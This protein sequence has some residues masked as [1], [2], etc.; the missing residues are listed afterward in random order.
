MLGNCLSSLHLCLWIAA[1]CLDV[2]FGMGGCLVVVVLVV[3]T[4][5]LPLLG[6]QLLVR[7]SSV[8]V[9]IRLI[10]LVLGL[11]LSIGMQ[12]I[13]PW[14]CLIILIFGLMVAGRISFLSVGLK[15]QALVF[16]CLLLKL[17]LIARCVGTAEEYGD[18]RLERCRAFLP[19]LGVMRTV[20]RAEFCGAILALQA[21]WPCHL[22]TDHLHV[23]RTIGR[24]LDKDCLVKPLPLI[25][26][27][28][29][30]ALVQYMIRTRGRG[31]VR[32]TKV[33]GHAEDLDV[34]QGRVRLKD[35]LV[36][37]EADTAADLGRRHQS[38]VLV[39]ARRRLLK[40]RSHW[41]PVMLHLHRFMIAVARVTVNHDGRGR[42]APD[43]TGIRV[44]QKKKA[45]RLDIFV[46]MLNLPLFLA[47]LVS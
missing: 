46:S 11:L 29:L 47:L 16:I 28:D 30:V 33:K 23:A 13:L 2:F 39:D 38:E 37:A 5:G 40:V 7:L 18:A 3:E 24:L 31:T 17:P 12:M 41:Y 25:K 4:L 15:W 44:V 43:P 34:Q 14:R 32:V 22:D 8:W 10:F 26:D 21:C 20:Q 19:F 36:N 27:G 6:T 45:G 9:L 35:Q 42:I 1:S